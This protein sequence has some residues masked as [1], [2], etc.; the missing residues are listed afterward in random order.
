MNIFKKPSNQMVP[1][2]NH[3]DPFPLTSSGD[4]G[5]GK[6]G[7]GSLGNEQIT[8]RKHKSKFTCVAIL[9]EF[10]IGQASL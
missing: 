6:C 4:D 2:L 8:F 9:V 5:V 1:S 3:F 10:L 7:E